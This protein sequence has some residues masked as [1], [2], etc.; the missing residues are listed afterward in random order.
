MNKHKVYS[1]KSEASTRVKVNDWKKTVGITLPQ[2]LV[3]RARKRNLNISRVTEQA[4]ASI[5]DYM[6]TQNHENNPNSLNKTL[7]KEMSGGP[8]RIRTGDLLHVKQMS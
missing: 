6:N 4:L 1:S 3:E 7:Q 2:N 5:L 8:N